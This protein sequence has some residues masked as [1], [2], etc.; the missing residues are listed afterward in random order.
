MQ[1]LLPQ[2]RRKSDEWFRVLAET[3]NEGLVV[4]SD[5]GQVVYANQRLR[6]ILRCP[7]GENTGHGVAEFFN[8]AIFPVLGKHM[9]CRGKGK[10]G[11]YE[12]AWTTQD[13]HRAFLLASW[14]PLLDSEGR[15]KGGFAI[16]SD[17]TDR[18]LVENA[19]EV[20]ESKYRS[21]EKR[22]EQILEAYYLDSVRELRSLSAQLLC[23]QEQERKRI[24]SELHDSVG[25]WLCAIKHGLENLSWLLADNQDGLS[26][27]QLATVAS[28]VQETIDEVRRISMDLRPPMLDDLGLLATINWYCGKFQRTY[29]SIRIKRLFNIREEDVPVPLKTVIFR[30]IQESL[31]NIAKHAKANHVDVYLGRTDNT[32]ALVI[33][34][35]GCGFDVGEAFLRDERGFGLASMRERAR[36]SGGSLNIDSSLGSG[37]VLRAE[38]PCIVPTSPSR[39]SPYLAA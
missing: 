8:D 7:E 39:T 23:G 28:M 31:T 14:K 36:L 35:N 37:S 32:L 2:E 22:M 10:I 5:N 29:S 3:M 20:S 25:Q 16:I 15:L 19:L 17:I 38:W 33:K 4:T 30:V 26:Q 13:G 34:D 1:P 9:D 27:A 18:K 21:H 24:A 6:E 12:I 11:R